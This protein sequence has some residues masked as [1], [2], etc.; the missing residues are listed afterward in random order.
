MYKL[1]YT[2]IENQGSWVQDTDNDIRRLINVA[3]AEQHR[4]DSCHIEDST[5]RAVWE[6]SLG[7]IDYEEKGD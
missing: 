2:S 7:M 6:P 3:N 1:I 4:Y 5:G